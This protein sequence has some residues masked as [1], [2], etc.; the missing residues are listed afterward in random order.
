VDIR[1]TPHDAAVVLEVSGVLDTP[2]AREFE[3]QVA[4]ALSGG[5]RHLVIDLGGAELLTSACIRVLVTAHRRL[6]AASGGLWLCALNEHVTEVFGVAGLA[7]HFQSVATQ[8]EAL[9]QCRQPQVAA[10]TVLRLSELARRML[11]A[12]GRGVPDVRVPPLAA[13]AATPSALA[14]R[15][16]RVLTR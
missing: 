12:L 2:A 9:A 16:R 3:Q 13:A 5:R 1:S 14:D 10:A 11:A 7:G 6:K 4:T 15:V 8:A